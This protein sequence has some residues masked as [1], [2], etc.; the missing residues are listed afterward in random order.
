MVASVFFPATTRQTL[1]DETWGPTGKRLGLANALTA[2]L[3]G[4][5]IAGQIICDQES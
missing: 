4:A 1:G 3:A 5:T 2:T